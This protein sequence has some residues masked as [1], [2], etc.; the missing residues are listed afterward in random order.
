MWY[1]D[2]LQGIDREISNYTTANKHVSM[3][4]LAEKQSNGVFYAV[5]A[6]MLQPGQVMIS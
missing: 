2:P 6:D 5:R 1:V 3:A 4:K